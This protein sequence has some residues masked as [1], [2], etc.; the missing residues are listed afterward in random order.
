MELLVATRILSMLISQHLQQMWHF[1]NTLK[2]VCN[3]ITT[4]FGVG[5]NLVGKLQDAYFKSGEP[6]AGLSKLCSRRNVLLHR[7]DRTLLETVAFWALCSDLY[8]IYIYI[9]TAN[10]WKNYS[11]CLKTSL[12]T[13]LDGWTCVNFKYSS[14]KRKRG[15]KCGSCESTKLEE[16]RKESE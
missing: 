8:F 4:E 16:S 12:I 6:R 3:L 13:I 2:C 1:P 9:W 11:G 10:P 15:E 14:Y 7:Q 5:C